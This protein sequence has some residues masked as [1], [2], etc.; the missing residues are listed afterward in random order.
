MLAVAE[1]K[2][3]RLLELEEIMEFQLLLHLQV[4]VGMD[5]DILQH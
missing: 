3:I 1:A 2:A 4:V 5:A